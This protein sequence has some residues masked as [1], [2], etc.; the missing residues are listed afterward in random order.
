M[1][2]GHWWI[3]L[4]F[5]VISN[6]WDWGLL[7]VRFAEYPPDV[8]KRFLI[9]PFP[10]FW[11][12]FA[13]LFPVS[14]LHPLL[15]WVWPL[16]LSEGNP[17]SR[18]REPPRCYYCA[19]SLSYR[20]CWSVRREVAKGFAQALSCW[21]GDSVMWPSHCLPALILPLIGGIC[22]LYPLSHLCLCTKYASSIFSSLQVLTASLKRQIQRCGE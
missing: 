8:I 9:L 18:T 16:L 10:S 1:A 7:M 14:Y 3:D 6:S 2:A 12:P 17:R 22:S 20:W 15:Y 21:D 5:T 11:L 13:G 19:I 4:K